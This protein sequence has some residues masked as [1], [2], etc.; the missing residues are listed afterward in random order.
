MLSEEVVFDG[1]DSKL[2]VGIS[3]HDILTQLLNRWIGQQSGCKGKTAGSPDAQITV[4]LFLLNQALRKFIQQQ[5]GHAHSV[6]QLQITVI[7]LCFRKFSPGENIPF[8]AGM[9]KMGTIFFKTLP[10]VTFDQI[11]DLTGILL[12]KRFQRKQT[13]PI[14]GQPHRYH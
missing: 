9:Y 4:T 10:L 8:I 5:S 14:L 1:V 11:N 12:L 2:Y 13:F 6:F 3:V 7:A